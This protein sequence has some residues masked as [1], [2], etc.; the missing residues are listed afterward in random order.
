M[1]RLRVGASLALLAGVLV[2]PASAYAH[3]GPPDI[4][5]WGP[6]PSGTTSCLRLMARAT[7]RCVQEAM[8]LQHECMDAQ[9][10]GQPCDQAARDQNINAAKL[11]ARSIV[12]TACTGGQLTELHFIDQDDA[13][14]DINKTCTDQPDAV[15]SVAY[16][17]A[18]AGGASAAMDDQ[19]RDCL[20]QTAANSRKLLHYIVRLKTR[21]L[22]LMAVNVIGPAKKKSLLSRADDHIAVAL[23][24][25][26]QRLVQACPNFE[27]IYGRS[28]SDILAAMT[29]VGDCVVGASYVQTSVACPA[30]VCGNGIKESG[31]QCDDDNTIDTDSCHNDCTTGP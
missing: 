2:P 5:F 15:M 26:A 8:T 28:P 16:A 24:K 17:P 25:L 3:G 18:L 12:T 13:K 11:A 23:D 1:A 14:A 9:L 30:P 6:F 27:A 31:E 22:D 7:Q 20:V 29:R 19:A 21:T 4:T 10:A